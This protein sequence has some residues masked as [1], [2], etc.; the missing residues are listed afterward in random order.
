MK[1]EQ[2]YFAENAGQMKTDAVSAN[3]GECSGIPNMTETLQDLR[4]KMFRIHWLFHFTRNNPRNRGYCYHALIAAVGY[5]CWAR[6]HPFLRLQW[7]SAQNSFDR[8]YGL[9]KAFYDEKENIAKL[10]LP[11]AQNMQETEAWK[12]KAAL[13]PAKKL[14]ELSEKL[15]KSLKNVTKV[16]N[17]CENL[18]TMTVVYHKAEEL[19]S[20]MEAL[21]NEENR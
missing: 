5:D 14:E 11:S 20:A 19:F 4:W 21:R 7:E 10:L 2:S 9:I 13:D 16:L 6:V 3:T 12:T 17:S 8:M 15:D 18:E 1:Q